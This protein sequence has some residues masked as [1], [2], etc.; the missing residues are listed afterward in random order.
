MFQLCVLSFSRWGSIYLYYKISGVCLCATDV[1]S[2]CLH[3]AYSCG[4]VSPACKVRSGQ[5]HVY[6]ASIH[7]VWYATP[8]GSALWP[9][10]ALNQSYCQWPL[11]TI[12]KVL[13]VSCRIEHAETAGGTVTRRPAILTGMR[14]TYDLRSSTARSLRALARESPEERKTRWRADAMRE[15]RARE[16]WE[17]GETRWWANAEAMREA[18][19]RESREEGET[20]RRAD[21]EAMREARARESRE[22]GE[23][24]RRADADAMREARARRISD[25][26]WACI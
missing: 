6:I 25:R 11:G 16:S 4:T 9:Q 1:T 13:E 24:R 10:A 14:R 20:R 17:E 23:T 19:A 7:A 12:W 3:R 5:L 2:P 21:S 22:E 18:R 15:A 8:S 26:G